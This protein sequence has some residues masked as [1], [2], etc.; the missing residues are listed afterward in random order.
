M[1]N[2]KEPTTRLSI[3]EKTMTEMPNVFTSTDF[4]R[5]AVKNGYP[6]NILKRK[7]L[8]KF[9]RR[10][11]DNGYEFSKTW[12]KYTSDLKPK[13]NIKI[14][15]ELNIQEMITVLKSLGYKIMKPVNEWEE[16]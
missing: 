2:Y 3:L 16:C 7:G 9:I 10:H 5:R 8:S 15:K 6:S 13:E 14:K 4:N 11:A 1:S 12:T